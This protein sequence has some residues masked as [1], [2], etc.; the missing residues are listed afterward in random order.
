[1]RT[2][3]IGF[4]TLLFAVSSLNIADAASAGGSQVNCVTLGDGD[5]YGKGVRIGLYLQWLSTFLLRQLGSWELKERLRTD[6]NI[7]CG[8]IMLTAAL[9]ILNGRASTIDYLL[10]YYLTVMLFLSDSFRM[11]RGVPDFAEAVQPAMFAAFAFFGAWFWLRGVDRLQATAC[12]EKVA[13]IWVFNMR[14]KWTVAASVL[15]VFTG[16]AAF[17]TSCARAGRSHLG[18][19]LAFPTDV[20]AE[21]SIYLS[22][23]LRYG[24]FWSDRDTNPI[25][26]RVDLIPDNEI[27]LDRPDDDFLVATA[28][29]SKW[30]C[31]AFFRRNIPSA[32]ERQS[33]VHRIYPKVYRFFVSSQYFGLMMFPPLIAITS[34]ERMLHA[35]KVETASVETSTGQMLSLLMGIFGSVMTMGE[36]WEWWR[37]PPDIFWAGIQ[38]R[39]IPA[40]HSRPHETPAD[41]LHRLNCPQW[42]IVR[43]FGQQANEGLGP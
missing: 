28:V 1:M 31:T 35:N 36:I 20:T 17:V 10:V 39:V 23:I 14:G 27:L 18:G 34:V 25:L 15:S 6:T 38:R 32:E 7:I 3:F 5:L 42:L 40:S 41:V 13:I 24:I 16:M 19:L 21:E 43:L 33:V 2:S 37:G 4:V 11:N 8:A 30:C 9:N 26:L 22:E 12:E 29:V